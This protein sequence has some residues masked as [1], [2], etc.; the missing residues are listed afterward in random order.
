[1]NTYLKALGHYISTT[2]SRQVGVRVLD[3]GSL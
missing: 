1:M 2:N 3:T